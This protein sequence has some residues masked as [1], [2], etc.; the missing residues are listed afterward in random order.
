[1]AYGKAKGG[2]KAPRYGGCFNCGGPHF[3]AE[4][5]KGKG[6][7]KGTKGLRSLEEWNQSQE[8]GG[9]SQGVLSSVVEKQNSTFQKRKEESDPE[10]GNHAENAIAEAS[11]WEQEGRRE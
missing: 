10:K 8:E 4:C 7:G 11:N 9:W 5:P 2:G 1:M 6:K 3:A